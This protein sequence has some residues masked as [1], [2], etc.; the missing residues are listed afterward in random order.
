MK[1]ASLFVWIL[2][3]AAIWAVFVIWGSPHIALS[4]RFLDNGDR[5]NPRAQRDYIDC[6]YY[7]ALGAITKSAEQGTCP[8]I[9]SIRAGDL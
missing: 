5:W 7:G 9:R 1:L 8:W 4:W 3:P 6:T 2:V